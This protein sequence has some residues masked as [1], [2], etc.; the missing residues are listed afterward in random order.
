ML[1][2]LVR[3]VIEDS[4]ST[5]IIN[6]NIHSPQLSRI[7]D[8]SLNYSHEFDWKNVILDEKLHYNK[9]LISKAIHIKKINQIG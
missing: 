8:Y 4:Q 5:K 2:I 3:F 6:K 1:H 9:R 7:M